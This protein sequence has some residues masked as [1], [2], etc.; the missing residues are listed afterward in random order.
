VNVRFV[1]IGG[2]V[3]H[4]CFVDIGVIVSHCCFVDIGVIVD[5][6]CFVDIGVIVDHDCFVDIGIIVDHDCFVDIGVIIDHDCLKK[7][8]NSNGD[9][10]SKLNTSEGIYILFSSTGCCI[11]FGLSLSFSSTQIFIF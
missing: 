7:N 1:D 2:I 3:D 9:L 5:H 10:Q 4:D 6:D 11:F 8:H